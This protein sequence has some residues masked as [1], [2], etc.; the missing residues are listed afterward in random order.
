MP[1]ALTRCVGI[2]CCAF[3]TACGQSRTLLRSSSGE[4]SRF[5]SHVP[6]SSATMSRPAWAMGRAATP[7]AA[8][9]PMMTTSVSLSRM[10]MAVSAVARVARRRDTLLVGPRRRLDEHRVV[11]RRLVIRLQRNPHALVVGSDDRSDAGIANQV[12]ADEVGVAAVERITECA[13]NRVSTDQVE[14]ARWPCW[15]PV[16]LAGLDVL[17]DGVL[18][19]GIELLE[20]CAVRFD[21]VAIDRRETSGVRLSVRRQKTR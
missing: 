2:S 10:A 16:G 6:A 8:P 19:G 13:L 20:R 7:P 14:E 12:P 1:R 15:K 17:Q 11:V 4:K 5:V 18:I 9:R 3:W 21:G